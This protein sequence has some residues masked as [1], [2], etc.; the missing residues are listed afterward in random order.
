LSPLRSRAASTVGCRKESCGHPV[1]SST[2]L[3]ANLAKN[4]DAAIERLEAAR[5]IKGR[6]KVPGILKRT[7]AALNS[8]THLPREVR[9]VVTGE[10]GRSTEVNTKL[11]AMGVEFHASETP[12]EG[13]PFGEAVAIEQ[14]QPV[15][16]DR[17]RQSQKGLTGGGMGGLA[18]ATQQASGARASKA[19]ATGSRTAISA[20]APA[21]R[22]P[23]SPDE[24]P[25]V[26]SPRASER[27]TTRRSDHATPNQPSKPTAK[28][29]QTPDAGCARPLRGLRLPG[30]TSHEQGSAKPIGS[31]PQV[32]YFST[33]RSPVSRELTQPENPRGQIST[34]ATGSILDRP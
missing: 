29:L 4:I 21:A 17:Q 23:K 28:T 25:S 6:I 15:K 8:G 3:T 22:T 13:K 20:L 32:A 14:R 19:T 9:L 12:L 2:A 16:K 7:K 27:P 34:G 10:G 5:D 1:R 26:S 30:Y 18:G 31:N 11:K 33:G 24:S